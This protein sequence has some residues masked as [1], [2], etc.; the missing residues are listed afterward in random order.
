MEILHI[1]YILLLLSASALCISLIFYVNRITSTVSKIEI[2]IKALTEEI[3]PLIDS[4][5]KLS[6][7]ISDISYE[8][9]QPVIIVKEVIEDIRDRINLILEFEEKLRMGVEGP[10]S[11]LL[12]SLSG[13]SNGINTFWATYKR[14]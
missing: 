14:R 2:D 8:A 13:I 5:T 3:K 9:K 11:K 1:F 6:E 7:K 12:N 4:T 10:L